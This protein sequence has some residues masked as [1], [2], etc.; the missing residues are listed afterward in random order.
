MPVENPANSGEEKKKMVGEEDRASLM[1]SLA[2]F[3]TIGIQLALIV[4]VMFFIGRWLDGMLNTAPWLMIICIM[5][6]IAFG[7]YKFVQTVSEVTRKE[8][9]EH[10]AQRGREE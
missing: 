5:V 7:L 4:V 2:P 3:F 1:R 9:Q 6:G 10:D 8:E